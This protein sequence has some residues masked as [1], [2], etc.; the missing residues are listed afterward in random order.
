MSHFY[1]LDPWSLTDS[2]RN[3][4]VCR[5]LLA[6]PSITGEGRESGYGGKTPLSDVAAA[7][8]ALLYSAYRIL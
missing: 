8:A 1:P 2:I 5:R 7:P 4:G 3:E 6:D